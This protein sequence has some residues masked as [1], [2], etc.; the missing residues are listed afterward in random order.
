MDYKTYI[1][2]LNIIL[3]G[4][5][6][7]TEYYAKL[8]R[9]NEIEN[10]SIALNSLEFT[11]YYNA[12]IEEEYNVVKIT[13]SLLYNADVLLF[14][15]SFNN[16]K[17]YRQISN[18]RKSKGTFIFVENRIMKTPIEEFSHT[19]LN[20]TAIT[21]EKNVIPCQKKTSSSGII[22]HFFQQILNEEL[23]IEE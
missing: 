2:G 19:N 8:L 18:I 15:L 14:D 5:T 3:I 13:P 7:T 20:I 21:T 23:C 11:M 6:D 1:N 22:N 10:V 4:C 12:Q 16:S 17:T 9:E